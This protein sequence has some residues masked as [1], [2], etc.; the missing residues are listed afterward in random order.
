MIFQVV[1]ATALLASSAV[2]A[3]VLRQE[4]V[5][6]EP[7]IETRSGPLTFGQLRDEL[8]AAGY[9]GP[10]E[11]A[12]MQTAY[13]NAAPVGVPPY[14]SN[15]S[16][17][18]LPANPSCGRDPWWLERNEVQNPAL[19][20]YQA[21]GPG[22][23]SEGSF[24]EAVNL[25][26]QSP[27]G[28]ELLRKS[29]GSG[30]TVISRAYDRQF[31]YATYLPQRNTIVINNR[32]LTAPSWMLADVLAHELSHASDRADGVHVGNTYAD[33]IAGELAAFHVERRFLIWL[34]R[35]LVPD[36]LPSIA[37]LSG[38]LSAEH[39]QLAET[40]YRLG[41]SNNIPQLVA[42]T[43]EGTC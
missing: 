15:T 24:V 13:A 14:P 35:T 32:F 31:A 4:W 41:F 2:H 37:T 40:L 19:V 36:G 8:A 6:P 28:Q 38:Q 7:T 39:G 43:Y 25:L 9:S 34:T 30:V 22:F 16:W 42:R 27:D 3:P 12:S 5:E 17:N 1:V 29:N 20:T 18:C 26:W 10:W 21:I 33:C 11:I 23:G